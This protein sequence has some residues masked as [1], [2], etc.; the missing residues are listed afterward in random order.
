[1]EEI[2]EHFCHE[3][4][5]IFT[6]NHAEANQV[7][8]YGCKKP[9]IWEES[10]Y[11]CVNRCGSESMILHKRCGELPKQILHPSHSQHP[12]HLF[13][14][15]GGHR[16]NICRKTLDHCIAYRCRSC[17]FDIDILCASLEEK[18]RIKHPSH[19]H[20]LTLTR[21]PAS[22]F[23]CD[24]CGS[25]D[26]DMAYACSSCELMIH[27][28][29]ASLPLTLPTNHHHHHLSLA[30][31]FPIKHRRFKY[32]CEIC[33]QDFHAVYWVYYCGDCRFFAHV[34]CATSHT[35]PH[36]SSL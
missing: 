10:A 30:F 29:C 19:H 26:R 17:D 16:C 27:K 8:C 4:P 20:V 25:E 12:L 2:I 9:V 32:K 21:K 33:H 35:R 6:E 36:S 22:L 14:F 1:M 15:E 23:Y 24:G 5:L 3:H 31:N 34:K 7:H 13:Q 28:T 11:I 18:S